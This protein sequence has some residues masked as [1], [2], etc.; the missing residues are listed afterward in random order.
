EVARKAGVTADLAPGPTEARLQPFA[1]DIV[2]GVYRHLVAEC[3]RR[4]VLPVWVYLP[5]PGVTDTPVQ[6]EAFV[7][8]AKEAGFM[9]VTLADWADGYRAVEVK[10]GAADA[11]PTARGHRL[12]AERLAA[13]LRGRPDALP[14]R[15]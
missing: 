5:L 1:R 3:R 15:D 12:I 4:G 9:V 14:A 7:G 2:R 6:A 11:H 10:G 13:A 8:V